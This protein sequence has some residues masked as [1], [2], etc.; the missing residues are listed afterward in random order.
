MRKVIIDLCFLGI[1]LAI[2]FWVI[3]RSLAYT[4]PESTLQIGSKYWSDFGSHLPLIRSFSLGQNWPPQHPLYPGEPIKYHFAFYALVGI[5][6]KAGVPLAFALNI[7][8]SLGLFFLLALIFVLGKRLFLSQFVSFVAPLFILFN[9]SL[10]WIEFLQKNSLNELT[11][12]SN[13]VS[14]GPWNGSQI[15]AIWTLNIFTNQRH[16]GISIGV[17]L[18]LICVLFTRNKK[19]YV[20]LGTMFGILSL[21]NMAISLTTLPFIAI[22]FLT[23]K[24]AKTLLLLSFATAIPWIIFLIT[25]VRPDTHITWH[26][27]YLIP[28]PLAITNIYIYWLKN[29]GPHIFLIPLGFLLSP[30]KAKYLFVPLLI[31]FLIPNLVQMSPDI[32]NNHK[33]FNVFII[34]G[35]LF[36]AYAIKRLKAIGIV[37]LPLVILGGIVDIFPLIN[38]T[39]VPLSD[40][41]KNPDV[42]FIQNHTEKNSVI[43]NSFWFYHPASLAG[44]SIFNGYPY[45]TWSYGYDE[46]ARERLTQTIYAAP[47]AQSA[48]QLLSQ[49]HIQYVEISPNHEQFI[50]LSSFWNNWLVA[51]TNSSTGLK[52][53]SVTKNC[54]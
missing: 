39:F 5:L 11:S 10:S 48:C 17:A 12:L 7:P 51:Y 49:N 18:W 29:L 9:G 1:C 13:F 25:Y 2:S 43:L 19:Y 26:L 20:L 38:E 53:Y 31:I 37:L 23:E 28:S 4:A 46:T 52:L 50:S 45:F 47:D 16:L 3:S 54:L 44:R 32:F 35:S 21:I 6:E 15:A 27:G 24:K 33:F 14:F 41:P 36:S 42:V 8:S 22:A 34:I 40:I 30:K